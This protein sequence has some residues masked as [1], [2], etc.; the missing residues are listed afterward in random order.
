[1]TSTQTI[2][3]LRGNGDGTF[4]ARQD[5]QADPYPWWV[6][7]ADFDGDQRPDLVIANGSS[8][9]VS[10]LRGNGDGTFRPKVDFPGANQPLAVAVGDLD[11]DGRPDLVT[12]DG[13]GTA[14][15]VLLLTC[16]P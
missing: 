3:V 16:T 7:V 14:V 4:K 15:T 9:S 12:A 10:L 13:G 2:S 5:A 6:S 1:M 11:G 8:N